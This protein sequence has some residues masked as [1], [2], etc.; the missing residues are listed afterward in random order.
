MA[1]SGE[2]TRGAGRTAGWGA[3]RARRFGA[4]VWALGV[5]L[6][7]YYLVAYV[8]H[9]AALARYPYDFDQGE[10]YDVNSG[11]LVARGLPIYTDNSVYPYYSSNYP[12]VFSLLLAPIVAAFGPVLAT[13]RVL[14][15]TAALLTA[16]LIGAVVFRRTHHGPVALTASLFYI[17]SNYV[18]H[19]TP[20]ARVNALAALFALIGLACCMMAGG[21]D[22]DPPRSGSR[23]GPTALHAG[24]L[25]GAVAAFLLALFTKQTTVD[26]VAAGLLFLIARDRRRGLAAALAVAILGGLLWLLLDLAHGGQFWLNV[27]VGNVNPFSAGQALAYYRNFL[28]LHGVLVGLAAWA[29][30]RAARRGT[31]GPF[32]LYWLA[33]LGLAVSVGKWGAGESYF[34]APIAASCVLAGSALADGWRGAVGRPGIAVGLGGL[35]LV[36]AGLVSHGAL[37]H[38]VP[39][40]A[41]RG[42]QASVLGREPGAPD[43]ESGA[44]LVRLLGSLGGPVLSEDPGYSLAAGK[45]VVGNATH[46]RNLHQAGVW[47]SEHL[48]EDLA[49]RR[50][51]WVVLDAELYPEPVLAAIGRYYYLFEEYTVDQTRQQVFAPGEQ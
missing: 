32:E 41:D 2:V 51:S 11:W 26:A 25:L 43:V 15:A 28:E 44:A 24:W 10:G 17:G 21:A 35:V 16:G 36:Q 12:P 31:W 4:V 33:A 6:L 13:G 49:A 30:W 23:S 8:D 29:A 47:R 1:P 9:V 27:V 18:Y 42:A 38:F 7:L 19:V 46:L 20:L 22:S 40:L 3:P 37:H 39:F 5:A 14:S 48:V 50:F 45:E 34:L